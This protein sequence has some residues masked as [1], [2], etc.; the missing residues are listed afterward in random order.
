MGDRNTVDRL[1]RAHYQIYTEIEIAAPASVVWETLTDFERLQQWSTSFLGLKGEF[2]QGGKVEA[3][4]RMFGRN[5]T[6]EHT[7]FDFEEGVQWAW[8]DPFAMGM[9]DH[10]VYRVEPL[11]E[12]TCRFTQ[13]DQVKGGRF[14]FVSRKIAGSTRQVY[15]GF[16]QQLKVEAERRYAEQ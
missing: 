1:D 11:T 12:T 16:N 2:R 3:T 9:V 7:L 15:E 14:D 6:F 4:F 13:T 5:R 10:H 8:S